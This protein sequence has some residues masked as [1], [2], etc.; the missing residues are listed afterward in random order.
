MKTCSACGVVKSR[1]EFHKNRGRKDGLTPRCKSCRSIETAAY[2]ASKRDE[3]N[4]SSRARRAANP[5]SSTKY[6]KKW[7]AENPVR[8]KELS[9]RYVNVRRARLTGAETEPVSYG[10]IRSQYRTC[11][12][13][14]QPLTG[15]VEMDH[16]IPLSKGG[17]HSVDNLLPTHGTCN[18]WKSNRLPSELYDERNES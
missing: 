18:N 6:V 17:K 16:V 2:R 13:C 9:D 12:L 4:A 14:C 1:E 8:A 10:V 7:R 3:L 5:G 15:K 11:Y